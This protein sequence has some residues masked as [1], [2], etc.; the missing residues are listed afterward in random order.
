MFAGR[1]FV[2]SQ[3]QRD[4]KS[5]LRQSLPPDV[6]PAK[7]NSLITTFEKFQRMRPKRD[8][9]MIMPLEGK[10]LIDSPLAAEK[11]DRSEKRNVSFNHSVPERSI[12]ESV[13]L[14]LQ[15]L[16]ANP[17]PS[18]PRKRRNNYHD[19][20]L[21]SSSVRRSSN[22]NGHDVNNS[23]SQED[24]IMQM[25]K[26]KQKMLK[27]RH[28]AREAERMKLMPQSFRLDTL[29]DED[30][31]NLEKLQDYLIY[32]VPGPPSSPVENENDVHVH[33]PR[34]DSGSSSSCSH[35]HVGGF[36]P[37]RSKNGKSVGFRIGSDHVIP[38][39]VCDCNC[40]MFVSGNKL[41][42]S[43]DQALIDDSISKTR[44]ANSVITESSSTMNAESRKNSN[45]ISR[46]SSRSTE[47]CLDH[48]NKNGKKSNRSN[49]VDRM[50]I[51]VDIPAV[52]FTNSHSPEPTSDT[53]SGL[54]K[55]FKQKELR[56]REFCNLLEDVK[57]LNKIS[58]TASVHST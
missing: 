36:S 52:V 5:K 4:R 56:Q 8:P 46:A 21:E 31:M 41:E 18:I 40:R 49:S 51:H 33:L 26:Q 25:Q 58:E 2:Y 16:T 54:A 37:T 15:R 57:E 12:D 17:I 43:F 35:G 22:T 6:T 9:P 11:S 20:V 44:E 13:R 14:N 47:R 10:S 55:A 1:E 24:R 27:M 38:T 30:K 39:G 19:I 32:F 48:K 29:S 50:R 28:E 3:P 45:T 23:S 7:R 34:I 53:P 42:T